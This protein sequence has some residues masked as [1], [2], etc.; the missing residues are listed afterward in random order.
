MRLPFFAAFQALLVG[1]AVLPGLAQQVASPTSS[2]VQDFPIAVEGYTTVASTTNGSDIR[3]SMDGQ[4]P[5]A[6][7]PTVPTGSLV[8]L[9]RPV[10][11]TLQAIKSGMQSSAFVSFRHLVSGRVSGGDTHTHLLRTDGTLRGTGDA[12]NGLLG[13]GTSNSTSTFVA[14]PTLAGVT[15]I[16]ASGSHNVALLGNSVRAWGRNPFGGLGDGST[17]NRTAPV[18][19]TGLSGNVTGISAGYEYTLFSMANGTVRAAGKNDRYQLGD[20]STTTRNTSVQTGNFTNATAVFASPY[21]AHSF[22]LTTN[23][24]LMGWGRNLD[25]Q[26]G[27]GNNNDKSTPVAA[28]GSLSGLKMVAQG[29]GFTLALTQSGNVHSWGSNFYGQLGINNNTA[30]NTPQFVSGLS[31]VIWISAGSASSMA[32]KRDGTLYTWGRNSDGQLG[33]GNTSHRD[34]PVQVTG[35]PTI[36]HAEMGGASSFAVAWDGRIYAWGKNSDGQLGDGTL[37]SRTSPVLI[38]NQTT[39][40]ALEDPDSDGL[41]TWQENDLNLDPHDAYSNGSG[42]MDGDLDLDGDFITGRIENQNGFDPTRADTNRDGLVDGFDWQLASHWKFSEGSGSSA[43]DSGPGGWTASLMGGAGFTTSFSNYALSL[44]GVGRY[45]QLSTN[46]SANLTASNYTLSAWFLADTLPS[47][48]G[49]NRKYALIARGPEAG[50]FYLPDGSLEFRHLLQS[51]ANVTVTSPTPLVTGTFHHVTATV[52]RTAGTAH[53][54]LN[55]QPAGNASFTPGATAGNSTGP[56]RFGVLDPVGS[57][58]RFFLPGLLDE[59]RFYSRPFSAAEAEALH[60]H[61][62]PAGDD[63]H[64]WLLD[65]WEDFYFGSIEVSSGAS[66]DT[67]GDG[68]DD[69][70]EQSAGTDPTKADGDGDGITDPMEPGL[71]GHWNFTKDDVTGQVFDQS[72]NARHGVVLREGVGGNHT[73]A[74]WITPGVLGDALEL[75]GANEYVQIP[76]V[77]VPSAG[78]TFGIWAK[79]DYATWKHDDV[80]ARIDNCFKIEP[81]EDEST[82]RFAIRVGSAW[83]SVELDIS[84]WGYS[85][86]DWHHYAGV[87]DNATNVVALYVDGDFAGNITETGNLAATNGTLTIG[88]RNSTDFLDGAVDEA[89]LYNRT[90]TTSELKSIVNWLD[91]D[92]DKDG[93]LDSWEEQIVSASQG[94][95]ASIERVMPYNDFD[96]DGI[97]NGVEHDEGT[98]P[99]AADD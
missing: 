87:F 36:V 94:S 9:D 25:G 30:K 92:R 1:G 33:I 16:S 61:A 14:T 46:A 8:L 28:G 34:E 95:I 60:A 17:T 76:S 80:L 19:P 45:A 81:V 86:S 59:I 43:A 27:I 54:Y 51:G 79:S 50:I 55:G 42:T 65:S 5:W 48:T 57:T 93:M 20:G 83:K 40:V 38:S 89:I 62:I 6:A 7:D 98:S 21:Y 66:S 70:F 77:S 88:K 31:D 24:T 26:L 53:L 12:A 39:I 82:V 58:D 74:R 32:L 91:P 97:S 2:L 3:F 37:A 73:A 85:V 90:L 10:I 29:Y 44:D 84:T 96:G 71:L 72:S 11:L 13:N 15:D 52:N 75:N 67:D 78:F 35:L 56:W 4:N 64:D 63:D 99:I 68:W 47:E 22:A 23:G 41:L 49:Q 69:L 18:T